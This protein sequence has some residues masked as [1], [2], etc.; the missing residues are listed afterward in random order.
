MYKYR[1]FMKHNKQMDRYEYYPQVRKYLFFWYNLEEVK[2]NRKR[3]VI[4]YDK[5]KA[6]IFLGKWI[7]YQ[8]KETPKDE[9][10]YKRRWE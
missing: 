2:E 10:L 6:I 5:D 3:D 8:N 9:C 7:D 1:I 4:F